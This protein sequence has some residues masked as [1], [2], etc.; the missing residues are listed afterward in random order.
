MDIYVIGLI[1]NIQYIVSTKKSKFE[2]LYTQI[3]SLCSKPSYHK[4]GNQSLSSWTIQYSTLLCFT[5]HFTKSAY[6]NYGQ[7][8]FLSTHLSIYK[9]IIKQQLAPPLQIS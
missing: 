9:S 6:V 1:S 7:H 8:N 2:E 3:K 5:V 4:I